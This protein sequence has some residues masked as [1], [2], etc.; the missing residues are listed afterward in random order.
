MLSGPAPRPSRIALTG[1]SVDIVP[2]DPGR[3][4][5]ALFDGTKGHDALWTY[6]FDGPFA[7]RAAFDASM[8]KMAA[9]QDPLYYGIVDRSDGQAVGRA[10]LMRIEPAHRVI[11]VGSILYTPRLQRTRGA[12]EAMYLMARYIFEDLGYR[13][14][15]WKC[16][17]LNEPSRS[18]ALRLGFTFEGIFRQHMIIKGKSRDTAWYSMI[19][20]EW[21]ARK[22]RFER[23]LAPENF[24]DG[25]RQR[26]SL[27][28]LSAI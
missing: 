7:N 5:D 8:Q 19:D 21:P 28:G 16:N 12:T 17:L 10:A 25:G 2:L 6:L 26:M 13:R 15:E 24:D 22:A 14:Y 4:G 11:E 9:S 3:H 18:A 20:A 27:T 1:Q 23:W